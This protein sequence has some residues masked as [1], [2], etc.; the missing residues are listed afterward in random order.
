MSDSSTPHPGSQLD[1]LEKLNLSTKLAYGVGDFGSAISSN[2]LIFFQLIFL[3]N[4]AGLTPVLAGSI[5]TIAG[6]WDAINDPIVGVLSDRTQT[7][8]GRRYPWMFLAAVPLGI[9][10]VLQWVVPQFSADPN[11]QQ[12]SLFWFY[13]VISIL[14]NVAFTAVNLPYTALTPELTQDYDE[15]TTLNQYRFTFSL[16]GAVL[17]LVFA[18]IVFATIDNP[19]QQYLFISGICGILCVIPPYLCIWGTHRRVAQMQAQ[20]VTEEDPSTSQSYL[21]Q[22]RSVFSNRPFLCV[23]GIYLF[24]WLALQ[25]TAAI[26][27]YYVNYWMQLPAQHAAQ[28]ALAV[29]G[30]A[31]L[32]LGIWS[33]ISHRLGKRTTYFLGMSLWMIAQIGLLFLQPGQVGVMYV[34][35]ILAGLGISVAYLIP[36]SMLPDVVELDV[37]QTGHR[38]EGIF[39]SF[40]VFLQKIGLALGQLI[41]GI[42][43][44]AAGFDSGAATQPDSALLAIRATIGP[45]PALFLT[46]GMVIAYFYPITREVYAEILLKLNERRTQPSDGDP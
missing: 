4:V 23:I 2:I 21:Q 42:V 11:T 19:L 15:R 46:C 40:M 33:S 22:L 32:V 24:S 8:W 29:Q 3:T 39:Y 28:V 12:I 31:V 5:R 26:I 44:E 18:Q 6:I 25:N 13:V 41:I 7:R 9:F 34:L 27:P 38:R 14:F 20:L 16:T 36:W 10:F 45:L 30:S 35:A 1:R 37:L 43:L 17:S